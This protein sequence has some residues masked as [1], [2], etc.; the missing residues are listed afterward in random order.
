MNTPSPNKA[1]KERKELNLVICYFVLDLHRLM[2]FNQEKENDKKR[3]R[4]ERLDL[5]N[6]KLTMIARMDKC[7]I[8]LQRR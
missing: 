3:K 2:P 1:K 7:I 8:T 4:R 6:M 5:K